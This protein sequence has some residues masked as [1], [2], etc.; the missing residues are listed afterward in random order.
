MAVATPEVVEEGELEAGDL[1]LEEG[2]IAPD[3]PLPPLAAS[4]ASVRAVANASS[5]QLRLG[6]I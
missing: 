5:Y 6:S 4:L 1:E 2:E 3:G